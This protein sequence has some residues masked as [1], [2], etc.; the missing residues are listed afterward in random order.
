MNSYT[1]RVPYLLEWRKKRRLLQALR[2]HYTSKAFTEFSL[3]SVS[4]ECI[5]F[6]SASPELVLQAT[7]E[8]RIINSLAAIAEF[9]PDEPLAH[10]ALW[11][12]LQ[13]AYVVTTGYVLE[14][15]P[16]SLVELPWDGINLADHDWSSNSRPWPLKGW[17]TSV[18]N[19]S[20]ITERRNAH[21]EIPREQPCLPRQSRTAILA[22]DRELSPAEQAFAQIPGRTT[23]VHKLDNAEKP[24]FH[25]LSEPLMEWPE[26]EQVYRK[27]C[28]YFLRQDRSENHWQGFDD[29]GF[30]ISRSGDARYLSY[31]LCSALIG[32]QYE[33]FD[34]Q[35]CS[36]GTLAFSVHVSMLCRFGGHRTVHTAWNAQV[37][38]PLAL[39]SAFVTKPDEHTHAAVL[40]PPARVMDSG[41][42]AA[43]FDWTLTLSS[44][45]GARVALSDE[46]AKGWLWLPHA[47]IRTKNFAAWCRRQYRGNEIFSRKSLGGRCTQFSLEQG[48]AGLSSIVG[49][50]RMAQACLGVSG[51]HSVMEVLLD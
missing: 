17:F 16:D 10:H 37:G 27:A 36:D 45:H 5:A 25:Q 48:V 18:D 2:F 32:Q 38:H 6:S 28:D 44:G 1:E 24:A 33:A 20:V 4:Y 21:L 13:L 23:K 40:K 34:I 15:H 3:L 49:G 14:S 11:E 29:I 47:D 46:Q 51:V 9:S 12:S 50:L 19:V 30:N 43:L 41:D 22:D 35:P 31:A 39:S 7:R 26:P 42:W 8:E